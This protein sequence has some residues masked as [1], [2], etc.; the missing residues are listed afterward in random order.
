MFPQ[1]FCRDFFWNNWYFFEIFLES[2]IYKNGKVIE[3]WAKTIVSPIGKTSAR[4]SNSIFRLHTKNLGNFSP[5]GNSKVHFF[6]VF[7]ILKEITI[8][9]VFKL[10]LTCTEKKL[11]SRK[12]MKKTFFSRLQVEKLR[13]LRD[14][15]QQ[16]FE[17]W[18]LHCHGH[19]QLKG[20]RFQLQN[21]SYP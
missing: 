4:C 7:K 8:I 18:N 19:F 14:S 6:K 9:R 12:K 1:E 17:N 5:K 16:L 2:S 13:S 11:G 10:H 20:K 3:L 21:K 15:F